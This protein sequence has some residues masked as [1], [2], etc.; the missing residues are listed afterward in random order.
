MDKQEQGE[1]GAPHWV[2]ELFPPKF[3]V[4]DLLETGPA[5]P[6]LSERLAGL[7][8][9]GI[10]ESYRAALQELQGRERQ[11]RKE[12]LCRMITCE[13]ASN[14]DLDS[15]LHGPAGAGKEGVG[16]TQEECGEKECIWDAKELS[17]LRKAMQQGECERRRLQ[18]RLAEA[19]SE[20]ER[21]RAERRQLSKALATMEQEL[22]SARQESTRRAL[23]LNTLLAEGLRKDARLQAL[24]TEA[25]E[26]EVDLRRLRQELRKAGLEAQEARVHSSE[27]AA[28]L[29]GLREQLEVARET[30]AVA[31]CV[32]QEAAV[33]RL[34][35]E[36]QATR[37]EL[38]AEKQSHACSLSA[39]DLLRRHFSS[40]PCPETH[41]GLTTGISQFS[42]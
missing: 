11:E 20:A 14:L 40:L 23:H 27:L 8:A 41:E 3:T 29:S 16:E 36:V 42:L 37:A 15:S 7:R 22:S 4:L 13:P 32:Q 6:L 28:E 26:K 21:Q 10:Q 18:T 19:L 17:A 25:R 5:P 34:Q 31:A 12:Q 39:L 38:E 24:A 2:A 33:Q 9:L 35:W 30:Q 1:S